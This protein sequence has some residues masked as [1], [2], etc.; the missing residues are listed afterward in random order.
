MS[1][2]NVDLPTLTENKFT[3]GLNKPVASQGK[4]FPGSNLEWA[5]SKPIDVK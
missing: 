1:I 2:T 3:W 5:A 4:L